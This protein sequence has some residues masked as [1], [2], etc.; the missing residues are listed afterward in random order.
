MYRGDERISW[1]L[2][3]PNLSSY[4][5]DVAPI[6]DFDEAD[7]YRGSGDEIYKLSNNDNYHMAKKKHKHYLLFQK[8]FN[9]C[10]LDIS[11]MNYLDKIKLKYIS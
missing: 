10:V 5:S 1:Q 7:S 4:R 9:K 6:M 3:S 2:S 11:F 8:R